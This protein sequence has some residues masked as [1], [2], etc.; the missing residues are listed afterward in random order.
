[1]Y[2]EVPNIPEVNKIQGYN[3]APIE[4]VQI[5][6]GNNRKIARTQYFAFAIQSTS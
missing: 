5:M 1:M 6:T 3:E 4:D 2:N